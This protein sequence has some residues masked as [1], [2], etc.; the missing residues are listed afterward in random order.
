VA[1]PGTDGAWDLIVTPWPDPLADTMY[2]DDD[3]D[4]VDAVRNVA[5]ER[6][7]PPAQVALAWILGR[8]GVTAPIVG[9][10]RTKHLED[11][12]AAVRIRLSEEEVA[13]L[14][15]PYRPHTVL[16]HN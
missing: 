15:A 2:T 4:V 13:T 3:F 9:A 12:V 1:D 8:P 10:T 6:D 5:A 14:Q 16:G 11:A 7:L